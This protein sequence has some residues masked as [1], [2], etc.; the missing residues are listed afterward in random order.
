[1]VEADTKQYYTIEVHFEDSLKDLEDNEHLF[2]TL[3]KKISDAFLTKDCEADNTYIYPDNTLVIDVE[4]N[5]CIEV[6]SSDHY[7]VVDL[8]D[9]LG[10]TNEAEKKEAEKEI[11]ELVE[12]VLFHQPITWSSA[13]GSYKSVEV[14]EGT[15]DF[16]YRDLIIEPYEPDPY[17]EYIDSMLE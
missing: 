11:K 6:D 7:K 14:G 13:M 2:D 5:I 16:D 4:A 17:D 10:F 3:C 8:L 1:M 12:N 9:G 15:I